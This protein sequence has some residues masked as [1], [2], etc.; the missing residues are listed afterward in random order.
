MSEK[1]NNNPENV[2]EA[3]S[4][5]GWESLSEVPFVG[6]SSQ[7]ENVDKARA[8]AEA[9]NEDMT[10]VARANKIAKNTTDEF[11]RHFAESN[12]RMHRF[13]ADAKAEQAAKEFDAT[14]NI[15]TP[16]TSELVE[17][18]DKARAMAE[19]SNEEMTAVAR[20]NKIAKNTTDEFQR[21]FAESSARVHR[22]F[23][24]GDAEQAA[25]DYDANN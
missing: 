14:Q 2:Q 23:A 5:N 16:D 18:I 12:A 3:G 17:D 25:K 1:L 20:A 8:M 9:A 24:D 6:N 22:L 13:F 10:I 19:A 21:R 11:Q 4:N 15:E 7:V